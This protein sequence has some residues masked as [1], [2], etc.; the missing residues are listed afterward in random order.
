M[1][2][3]R[4]AILCEDDFLA[5]CC[6]SLRCHLSG[7][8]GYLLAARNTHCGHAA[9]ACFET[10]LEDAVKFCRSMR[11]DYFDL[12]FCSELLESLWC[13]STNHPF[14]I[15]EMPMSEELS[16]ALS[17]SILV[18]IREGLLCLLCV[19]DSEI[20]GMVSKIDLP[21]WC[22]FSAECKLA[23][24]NPSGVGFY[25]TLFKP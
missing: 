6:S 1:L 20:N 7:D 5:A 2:V 4:T 18:A 21:F 10:H 15:E 17:V 12:F 23:F 22:G 16:S 24:C 19:K 14:L 8:A 25:F 13:H 9:P 3:F 11:V